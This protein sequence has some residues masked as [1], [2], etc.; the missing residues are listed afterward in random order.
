MEL[1]GGRAC[2]LK[3]VPTAFILYRCGRE[4]VILCVFSEAQ[5]S[6]FTNAPRPNAP[7]VDERDGV[8]VVMM[9]TADKVLCAVGPVPRDEL[10]ALC[11]AFQRSAPSPK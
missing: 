10:L 8:V 4:P 1:R 3:G 7:L 11:E 9:C 6:R 5:L 2:S